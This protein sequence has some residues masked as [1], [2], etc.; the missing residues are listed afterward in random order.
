MFGLRVNA[1][2]DAEKLCP[3]EKMAD[4]ARSES[5]KNFEE[6]HKS[7]AQESLD[8]YEARMK[9]FKFLGTVS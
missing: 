6:G 1:V 3:V 2:G 5:S 7:I 9:L 8:Y 4:N